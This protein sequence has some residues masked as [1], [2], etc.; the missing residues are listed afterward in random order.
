V[1]ARAVCAALLGAVCLLAGGC[2]STSKPSAASLPVVQDV[3]RDPTD[4]PPPITRRTAEHVRVHL[5]AKEVVA[6][7]DSERRFLFWTFEAGGKAGG[8]AIAVPR[9]AAA[10]STATSCASSS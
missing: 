7:L 6:S 3:V 8:H 1:T 2:G 9:T 4:V 5:I 10:R